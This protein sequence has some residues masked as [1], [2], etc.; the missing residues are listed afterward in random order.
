MRGFGWWQ[1]ISHAWCVDERRVFLTG[2]NRKVWIFVYR[3]LL[4]NRAIRDW[5]KGAGEVGGG[6]K[7]GDQSVTPPPLAVPGISMNE[8]L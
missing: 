7:V 2:Q 4:L 8:D 3:E 6:L 1:R 5:I